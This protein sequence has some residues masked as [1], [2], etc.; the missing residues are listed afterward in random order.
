M[1]TYD[2]AP[3]IRHAILKRLDKEPGVALLGI[4]AKRFPDFIGVGVEALVRDRLVTRS[5]FRLPPQFAL[6]QLHNEIDQ[7]A[8][9]LK[10]AWRDHAGIVRSDQ[11]ATTQLAG[12]GLGGKGKP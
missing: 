2:D 10:A 1:L 9:Q 8:E 4:Y 11:R 12:T 6:Q 3:T 5:Q 7:I